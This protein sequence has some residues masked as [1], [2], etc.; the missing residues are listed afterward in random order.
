[1]SPQLHRNLMTSM[2]GSWILYFSAEYVGMADAKDSSNVAPEE[3]LKT[4]E[5]LC[6]VYVVCFA[7]NFG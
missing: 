1:M 5:G 7:L 4:K 3:A 6:D 2:D